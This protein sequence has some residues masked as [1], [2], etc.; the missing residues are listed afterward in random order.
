MSGESSPAC[1]HV[2]SRPRNFLVWQVQPGEKSWAGSQTRARPV[3]R[4][5]SREG[6]RAEELSATRSRAWGGLLPSSPQAPDA[7]MRQGVLC[8]CLHVWS[9]VAGGLSPWSPRNPQCWAGGLQE[10]GAPIREPETRGPRGSC[11]LLASRQSG[12]SFT[13]FLPAPERSMDFCPHHRPIH[14]TTKWCPR[15]DGIGS[16]QNSPAWPDAQRGAGQ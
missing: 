4:T 5:R 13:H 10:G 8:G 9:W 1:E 12:P 14:V 15:Q 6:G 2:P 7:R 11:L 3:P 16:A